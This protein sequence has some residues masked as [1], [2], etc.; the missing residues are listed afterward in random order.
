MLAI[1]KLVQSIVKALHSEGTPGQVAV[2]IALGAVIGLL[3]AGVFSLVV[4]AVILL[5][6]VSFPGA[7]L[8]MAVFTPVGFLLDPVFDA[9]GRRLLLDSPALV[10]VWTSLYN[11]PFAPLTNF[12]NTVMMGAMATSLALFIPLY[13]GGRW[14]IARYRETVGA[15]IRNSSWYKAVTA[16]KVYNM[17]RLFKPEA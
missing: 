9:V 4:F 2:G 14:G 1:I 7:V 3:P 16:S 15:R 10:P 5:L 12:N 11:A 17:Y 8:G 6:N 13:V